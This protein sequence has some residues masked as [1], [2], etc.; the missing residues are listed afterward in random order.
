MGEAAGAI[1]STCD[2]ALIAYFEQNH[3]KA[4]GA[5]RRVL[6]GLRAGVT[7]RELLAE[8]VR[9]D[10]TPLSCHMTLKAG[11]KRISLASPNGTVIE[12]G[13]KWSA[14][15][16]YWGTNVCR[17]GF[18][19]EGPEELPGEARGY[20]EE[21]VG[22]Y[23]LALVEWLRGLRVGA[24][25]SA[26][27]AQVMGRLP[28]ERYGVTLNPGHLIHYDEW[29]SSPFWEGS[30]VRLRS[31]MVVQSDVIPTHPHWYSTRMEDGYAIA[32]GELRRELREGYPKMWARV[33]QRR[34]VIA[35]LFGGEL[36]EDVLPLGE[37]CGVL[38][39]YGFAPEVVMG[40]G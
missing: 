15:I 21:F 5:M 35:G 33:E 25:G 2:A 3:V 22:P 9:Y 36:N 31:G 4:S 10:G 19:V 30:G 17:A 40:V 13:H 26:L 27:Y 24:E 39:P 32:D 37:T 20:V 8:S 7:D 11:P 29:P 28:S 16:G 1:R 34:R 23:F 12:R 18:A 38:A 14:N 6:F